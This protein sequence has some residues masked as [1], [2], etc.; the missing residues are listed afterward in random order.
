VGGPAF[1][2][3]LFILIGLSSI[4]VDPSG[5]DVASEIS[6]GRIKQKGRPGWGRPFAVDARVR[7][8][9]RSERFQLIRSPSVVLLE[10]DEEEELEPEEPLGER[11]RSL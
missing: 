2:C 5:P 8:Y 4:R 11:S 7:G 6:R 9:S 1:H 3:Y 10:E